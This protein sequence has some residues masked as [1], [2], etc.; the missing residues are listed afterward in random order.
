[1]PKLQVIVVSTRPARLGLAVAEWFFGRAQQHAR[2]ESELVDLKEVN[3]PLFDEPRHPRF[4]Q[5]EH[6]H[7]RAWS[8]RVAPADAFVFVTPEYN[9]AAPPSLVNALD[10]LSAEWANKPAA[11]VSYGGIS[12]GTRAVQMAKPILLA[13][14][15]VPIPESVTIPM[16]HHALDEERRFKGGEAF[17][18]S[19]AVLLDELLRWA[20]ALRALRG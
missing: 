17:E 20:D 9:H 19:A 8:A 1:M 14:R 11:F 6:E 3:L 15:M 5:Y 13:L 12:G 18:K 4:G 16:V 2:F 10:F 7:T